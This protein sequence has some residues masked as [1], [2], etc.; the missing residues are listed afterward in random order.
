MDPFGGPLQPNAPAYHP[1][2]R[3]LL[4]GGTAEARDL[5]ARLTSADIPHVSSLAGR[6]STPRLPF[7]SVR[8]GGFGGVEGLVAFMRDGGFSHL[9]DATHP[10]AATMS[11]HAAE[12]S[13][14]LGVPLIRLERPGWGD[15]SDAAIWHWES[16]LTQVRDRAEAL[17]M[18][19]FITSGR[20][21]L[22]AFASWRLRT[23]LVRV[24]EPLAVQAPATWTVI[25]D[26]GPYQR[27]DELA[28]LQAH[29]I[30]VLITKDS[31]GSHTSAKLD[32]A[33]ELGVPV[34]VLRR[35]PAAATATVVTNVDDCLTALR[36]APSEG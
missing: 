11:D 12:A 28:L 35:P 19:P 36:E 25:E 1:P 26:R 22:H 30:D 3:I 24:V 2:V 14:V 10:F 6:V 4:L 13:R 29:R 21:T 9:I 15:R 20:Q 34:V 16:D 18:R 17:G 32:A 27:A 23:V 5:A 33:A 7:G 8:V 31:G